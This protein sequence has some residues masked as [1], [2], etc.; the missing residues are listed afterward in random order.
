MPQAL[1][2]LFRPSVQPY[3]ISWEKYD[4]AQL[5]GKLKI[6]VLIVQGT[7]DIQVKLTDARLLSAA[8]PSAKLVIIEGMNHLMKDVSDDPAAQ[9]KS[10]G[11]SSLPI[12]G[13]LVDAVVAFMK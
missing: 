12:D 8:A 5:M 11:D 10:Y 1:A 3:L 6:P 9:S 13:K 2:A 7:T 4:P